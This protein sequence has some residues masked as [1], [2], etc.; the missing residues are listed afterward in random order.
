MVT[1]ILEAQAIQHRGEIAKLT[2]KVIQ[3]RLLLEQHGIEAPDQTG[4]EL[5]AMWRDC[6]NVIHAA[7]TCVANLGT[8]KEMLQRWS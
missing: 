3:Y 4:E 1:E 5:L 7:H 6:R 8:S 2:M